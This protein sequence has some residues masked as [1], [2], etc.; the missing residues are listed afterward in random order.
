MG[1]GTTSALPRLTLIVGGSRSGKSKRAEQM[2]AGRGKLLYVATAQAWDAEM[3]ARVAVHQARRGSDWTTIEEP[4]DLPGLIDR[5]FGGHPTLIDCLTLWLTNVMLA[6]DGRDAPTECE[7]LAQALSRAD[8][9][10]VCVTNEVGMSIVPET[11]LGRRFRD[12]AGHLNQRVA[13]VS[14][15]VE[16]VC[17]GLPLVL[18]GA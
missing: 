2:L 10:I 8:G 11:P 5:G 4:L 6:D 12:L 7:R 18:K 1:S 16:L 14:D 3:A 13:E 15:R 9:P 17:A